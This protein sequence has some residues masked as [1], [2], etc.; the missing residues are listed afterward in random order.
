[1]RR[2]DI[3][4][5]RE[6]I[7]NWINNNEP[8]AFICRQIKCKPST[9]DSYLLIFGINYKGNMGRKGKQISPKRQTFFELS[10]KDYVGSHRLK[11]R[12]IQDGLKKHKCEECCLT[13]WNNK[14]IP[15]ELHHEDGNRFNNEL[16]NLKILCPNCHAQT[17]N[18]SCRKR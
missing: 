3:L 5:K 16:S 6:Q 17:P 14:P 9:L 12:L 10:T 18:Y 13:V 2:K 1:M 11:K 8:K 15:I 4:E 7:I